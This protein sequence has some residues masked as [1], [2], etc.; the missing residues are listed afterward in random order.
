M[1]S[2][3][4]W[5]CGIY[6]YKSITLSLVAKIIQEINN[7]GYNKYIR[8]QFK[9]IHKRIKI[10]IKHIQIKFSCLVINISFVKSKFRFWVRIEILTKFH[11]LKNESWIFNLIG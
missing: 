1:E 9:E 3:F 5:Y 10:K 8:S 6:L 4:Y 11:S 7:E 2:K